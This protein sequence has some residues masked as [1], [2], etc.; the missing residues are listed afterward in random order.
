MLND[1]PL[2]SAKTGLNI[3]DVLET[4]VEKDTSTK[5]R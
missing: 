3:E 5:W 4:V 1:A 2:I